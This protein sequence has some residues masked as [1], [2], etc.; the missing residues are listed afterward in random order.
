MWGREEERVGR[1]TVREIKSQ[2]EDLNLKVEQHISEEK[3]LWQINLHLK[4]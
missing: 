1:E 2:R 3:T 4:Y